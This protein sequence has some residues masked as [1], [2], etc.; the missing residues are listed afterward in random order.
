M[1]QEIL[2]FPPGGGPQANVKTF[3]GFITIGAAGVIAAQSGQA[4]AG[5]TFA[6]NA[7]AGRYD[8]T[9]HRAYKRVMSMDVQVIMPGAGTVPTLADGNQGFWQ[10]ITAAMMAPGGAP[11]ALPATGP[12]IQMTRSDTQAA[13]NPTNGVTLSWILEVSDS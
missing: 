12:C 1:P 11:T 3:R 13:A 5:V 10:G 7:A 2:M 8:A 4:M 6:K 9:I